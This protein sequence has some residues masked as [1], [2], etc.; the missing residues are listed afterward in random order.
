MIEIKN[1]V[2]IYNKGKTNEFCALKGIDLS[3]EEGEM[4]AIIGKS[5]A[6]KSTLLH[7]LAAIDSY[8]K[9]SYLVDGVSVGDLKEKDRAR[10][11][12]QKIGI[13]MQDYALIDEY[14]I[15]ENVQIPLIFGKVKGNDVRR[16][17]IMTA[18]ENVGLAELAKKP[19]RQLSG[20]QKQRVAIARALVNNPAFLLADEPTGALDYNTG[21]AILK[22]LQDMCRERGMTVIVITHNSALTPMADRVIKIKNGKVSRMTMND[23]PTPI[24]EIEW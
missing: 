7:I 6:G 17:K 2:K 4:V 10:F 23:H 19:V 14:T 8:D 16:E 24:E 11:R 18:L 12:N 9:G 20:G 13:V 5:G 3:I 15:E 21:K 22:L 1:L